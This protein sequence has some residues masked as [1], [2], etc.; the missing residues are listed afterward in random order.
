MNALT[1]AT[2]RNVSTGP[3]QR[4]DPTIHRTVSECSYHGD[5]MRN[6]STGPPQRIDPT[7]HRT[8]SE[9]SYHGDTMRN[10]STGPPQRIDPTTH[11]TVSECSYQSYNKKHLNGSTMKDRSDDPPH[12]RVNALTTELQRETSQRV[13]HEGSIRRPTAPC[14]K[15]LYAVLT[16]AWHTCEP[17]L[18]MVLSFWYSDWGHTALVPVEH[19]QGNQLI[20]I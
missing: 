6:V 14:Y 18:Q 2:T 7:I 1:R 3:P 15:E 13:H 17:A 10:V 11:R 5:T 19:S 4:I 16:P 20:Y 8:V 12:C 9:C